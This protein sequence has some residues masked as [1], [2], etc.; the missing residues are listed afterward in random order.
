[1]VYLQFGKVTSEKFTI[2]FRHPFCPLQAFCIALS[3]FDMKLACE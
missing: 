3:A 2:D 1:M